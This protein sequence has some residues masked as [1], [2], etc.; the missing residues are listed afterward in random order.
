MSTL[1]C[2]DGDETTYRSSIIPADPQAR[3]V[4]G[5]LVFRT[6]LWRRVLLPLPF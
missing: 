3:R 5:A 6:I 1:H 2:R 4:V